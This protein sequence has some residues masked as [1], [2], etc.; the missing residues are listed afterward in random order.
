MSMQESNNERRFGG[1][2]R[3]YGEKAT[4]TFASAHVMVA[5]I[6]GVGSWVVEALARSGVGHLTLA[7]LDHVAES[8]VNRQIHALSQTMGMAK[9][10]AMAERVA[11]INPECQVYPFEDFVDA[12]NIDELLDGRRPDVFID[13]TD[14]VS[15]KVAMVLACRQHKIP[16]V[17]CGGAGGKTD[18]LSL[19]AGDLSQAR[20]DALLARLRNILRKQHG[21][22][23]GSD[24]NGKALKRVPKMNVDCFWFDQPA[25]LPDLWQAGKNEAGQAGD[26]PLQ[27]LSCA[28]YGS[29]VT[30][31]ATMGMAVANAGIAQLLKSSRR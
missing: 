15:A 21:F 25:I 11:G 31:T 18:P 22:A 12:N 30:V 17:M 7:D 19:R 23:K 29:C 10:Q 6:G 16:L 13:C 27:G 8:N 2:R 14:Q 9:V 1:L 26:A 20:N 4:Q 3:L 24:H 5:G 28:G